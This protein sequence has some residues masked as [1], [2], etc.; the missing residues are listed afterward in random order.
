MKLDAAQIAQATGGALV[1]PAPPGP[2]LTDTRTLVPGAWFLALVGERFDGHRFLDQAAA[3]GAAGVVVDRPVPGWSGGLVQVADTTA[4]M[5]DLGRWARQQVAGPVVGITGSSGKT[6]TRALVALAL[7]PLGAIHQTV[8]NLNNHLG[9]P[10][11]LL[12]TPSGSSAPAAMVVEMGTSGPGEIALL[13]DIAA[14]THRIVINV[15]PAHLEELGGLGGVAVEKGA[16]YDSAGP[17]DVLIVNA[18]QP[19]YAHLVPTERQ[20]LIRF[21]RSGAAQFRLVDVVLDP[22]ML[23]TTARISTPD[24]DVSCAI[25]A[26]GTHFAAN[27][28]AALAVAWGCGVPVDQAA[29]AMSAYEPVG[30]RQRVGAL[31]SGGLVLNDAYNANPDSVR[32]ALDTLAALGGN[33]VAALGDML[34]LGA[35]E[36]ELHQQVIAYAVSL[37]LQRV[38][39]VGPRMARAAA[40]LGDAAGSARTYDTPDLAAKDLIGTIDSSTRLLVKGS[41]GMAMERILQPLLT[42][43]EVG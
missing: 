2:V 5:A 30:M 16:I 36:A 38:L 11:T 34:E 35:H 20:R 42:T 22:A 37:G 13:A 21:G 27:A 33:G 43:P 29:A 23:S 7:S 25:P 19:Y 12:A 4:A 6:T 8:G 10:M 17:D 26:F 28:C 3:A 18:D 40:V 9:V 31:P 24:G 32:A 1:R 39:L 14:P 41:R 15:G